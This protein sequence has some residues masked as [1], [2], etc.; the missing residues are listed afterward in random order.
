[1]QNPC[2]THVLR[3]NVL[4]RPIYDE[5]R[6]EIQRTPSENINGF[7]LCSLASI[8]RQARQFFLCYLKHHVYSVYSIPGIIEVEEKN[9][10]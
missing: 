2:M 10:T 3:L 1:M 8:R 6:R 7:N 4:S 5:P 9:P